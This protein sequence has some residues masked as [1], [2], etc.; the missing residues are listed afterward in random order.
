MWFILKNNFPLALLA[1]GMCWLQLV[2]EHLLKNGR[3]CPVA[4]WKPEVQFLS[5][6]YSDFWKQKWMIFLVGGTLPIWLQLFPFS[7]VGP[8]VLF[9][10]GYGMEISTKNDIAIIFALMLALNVLLFVNLFVW[11]E[12]WITGFLPES[13]S[14]FFCSSLMILFLDFWKVERQ[15]KQAIIETNVG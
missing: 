14:A 12:H 15:W 4:Q 8:V 9:R 11:N 3:A 6:R 2:I 10:R 7:P 13:Y 1:R 5:C